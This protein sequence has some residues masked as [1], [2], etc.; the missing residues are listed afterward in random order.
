MYFNFCILVAPQKIIKSVL[1][2]GVEK[3]KVFR[4][5]PEVALAVP[6]G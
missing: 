5:K 6:G 2:L 4:Y 1:I 3:V